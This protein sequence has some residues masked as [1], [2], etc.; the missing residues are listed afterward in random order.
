MT[1]PDWFDPELNPKLQSFAQH[2]GTV[3][4]PTKPR[5]PRHK[6]KIERGIGYVKGNALKAHKFTA[7]EDE[8]RH[9]ARW[10]ET[11]ADTRI[12]G[13]TKRQVGRVFAAV[14]RPALLPLPA[15]RF[16]SFHEAKRRV[17]RDGHIEVAKAY[18]SVPT[19]FLGREVWA[20][21]DARLVRV[22]DHRFRQ[23]AIHVRHEHGRFSTQ[24]AHI[25]PEKI[26]GLERGV[27]WLL[28]RVEWIGPQTHAWAEAMVAARG[29]EGTRVLQGLLSLAKKHPPAALEKACDTALSHGASGFARCASC[30]S[31]RVRSKSRCHSWTN[32]RL[33]VRSM[34]MHGSSPR[35]S[36]AKRIAPP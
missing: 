28:G 10:E 12:H 5:T 6:G 2:Y 23:I 25:A 17:N 3:I 18:Y 19:E 13:T 24:A 9:L 35:R 20:R 15:E 26:S 7:L 31:A 8:N 32:T 30:S 4:L 33:S 29:I 34:T 16:P 22:F 21:W 1:H 27:A 36:I 14:E 11:V